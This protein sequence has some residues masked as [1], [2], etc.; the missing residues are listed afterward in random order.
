MSFFLLKAVTKP[1]G[2]LSSMELTYIKAI[3]KLS[4][5]S[6]LE[7]LARVNLEEVYDSELKQVE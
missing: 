5:G 6:Y 7:S 4:S 3:K 2:I 1:K